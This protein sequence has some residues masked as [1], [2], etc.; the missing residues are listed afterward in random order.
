MWIC[1]YSRKS[2]NFF[3]ITIDANMAVC[4][5][6]DMALYLMEGMAACL[7]EDMAVYLMEDTDRDSI[8]DLGLEMSDCS[9]D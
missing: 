6:E 5:I 7:M 2:H 4:L 9:G 8:E 3:F 1:S